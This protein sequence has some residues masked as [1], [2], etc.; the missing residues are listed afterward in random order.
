[1]RRALSGFE[2]E[3]NLIILQ[4]GVS[5]S[6]LHGCFCEVEPS[7]WHVQAVKGR[8]DPLLP[9]GK[10]CV[11]VIQHYSIIQL[12]SPTSAYLGCLEMVGMA[13]VR[14][15]DKYEGRPYFDAFKRWFPWLSNVGSVE[16][17]DMWRV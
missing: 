16:C 14:L 4:A 11:G 9:D 13:Y 15:C 6:K 10:V 2:E 3:S 5:G 1:M 8:K 7:S 12:Y 17:L